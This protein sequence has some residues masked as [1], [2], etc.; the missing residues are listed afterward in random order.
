MNPYVDIGQIE[1]S[2]I[3]GFGLYTSELVKYNPETGEK[4][5]NGTWVRS[6]IF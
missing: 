3:M 2:V 1:G 6:I 4:L 5:S